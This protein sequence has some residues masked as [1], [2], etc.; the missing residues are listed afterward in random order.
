MFLPII[1]PIVTSSGN[2]NRLPVSMNLPFLKKERKE[3]CVMGKV[4]LGLSFVVEQVID[5]SKCCRSSSV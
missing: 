1:Y 4:V 2:Q 5:K 3:I